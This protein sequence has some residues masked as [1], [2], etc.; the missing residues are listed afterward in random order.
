M[1][2]QRK[3]DEISEWTNNFNKIVISL[4]P[5]LSGTQGGHGLYPIP[6]KRRVTKIGKKN[7]WMKENKWLKKKE[8]WKR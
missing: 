1:N 7:Q 3:T 6:L 2:K 5:H 8:K 4:T